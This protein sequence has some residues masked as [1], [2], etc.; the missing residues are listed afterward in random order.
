MAIFRTLPMLLLT[1]GTCS[2]LCLLE[3]LAVL[4]PQQHCNSDGLHA[5]PSPFS[6][7]PAASGERGEFS[8][9][10]KAPSC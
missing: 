2:L 9:T 10:L 8:N 1:F 3:L 4:W 7:E 6:D 5:F